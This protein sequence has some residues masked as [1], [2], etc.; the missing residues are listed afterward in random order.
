MSMS[1]AVHDP[2]SMKPKSAQGS[3]WLK[4]ETLD[5]SGVVVFFNDPAD[6]VRQLSECL[7]AAKEM[8]AGPTHE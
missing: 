3:Y 2:K 1:A 6:M 7:L 5:A 8:E 4:I